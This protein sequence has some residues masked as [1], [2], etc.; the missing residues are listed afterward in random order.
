MVKDDSRIINGLGRKGK[1][2]VK[3]VGEF[4]FLFLLFSIIEKEE[5]GKENFLVVQVGELSFCFPPFRWE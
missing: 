3:K 1:I 2:V 4:A 5:G